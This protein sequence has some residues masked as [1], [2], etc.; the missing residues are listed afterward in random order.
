M[1]GKDN[2]GADHFGYQL[3]LTPRRG[4]MIPTFISASFWPTLRLGPKPRSLPRGAY[5]PAGSQPKVFPIKCPVTE[6]VPTGKHGSDRFSI[7][8]STDDSARLIASMLTN[9]WLHDL[10]AT[11]SR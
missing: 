4:V 3:G 6:S 9:S 2:G 1:L 8:K 5:V 7:E 11:T 10:S